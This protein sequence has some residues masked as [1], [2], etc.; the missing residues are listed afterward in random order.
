MRKR[1]TARYLCMI[2]ALGL[3]VPAS[4][5]EEH[6]SRRATHAVAS[7]EPALL[8]ALSATSLAPDAPIYVRITKQPAELTVYKQSEGG[9]YIAFRTWPICTFSGG[10]GPKHQQGDGKSPEGFYAASQDA[11]N[12]FSS[13]HLSFNLGYPNAYD[14]AQGY[15]GDYLMVHGSCVSIG[16]YAMTDAGIEEI[17]TLMKMAFDGG[18]RSIPVHIFPFEMTEGW[19][20]GRQT[21]SELAF[22]RELEPAWRAFQDTQLPP[23]TRVEDGAYIIETSHD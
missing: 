3:L 9:P 10:L 8:E 4:I 19:E 6:T 22:W 11:M 1:L 23:A 12:P 2:L 13:Y 14:R 17:W 7:Q 20:D 16:C 5:A 18:Q 15:T 21:H